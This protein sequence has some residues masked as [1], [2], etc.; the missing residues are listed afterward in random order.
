MS[1]SEP[2]RV[3]VGFDG[4]DA[5]RRA[6]D[7][8]AR[9]AGA[10]GALVVVSVRRNAREAEEGS[11]E[12]SPRR[13]PAEL[14]EDARAHLAGR[15]EVAL[16]EGDGDVAD[17]LVSAAREVGADLIVMGARGSDFVS[18]TLLG[19]VPQRLVERAPYDIVV[20]R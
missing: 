5:A 10:D 12:E 14:L 15:I 20:V 9:I 18:R 1:T 13:E 16:R 3:V 11:G 8:A 4:S 7:R 2:A 17:A 19:S 6:L